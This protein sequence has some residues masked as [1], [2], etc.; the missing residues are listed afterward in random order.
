[1]TNEQ[2]ERWNK[3]FTDA[4]KETNPTKLTALM[5]EIVKTLRERQEALTEKKDPLSLFHFFRLTPDVPGVSGS[6]TA[7][8]YRAARC[9]PSGHGRNNLGGRRTCIRQTAWISCW[10]TVIRS[11]NREM[12]G[13]ER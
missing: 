9:T 7:A 4:A 8:P 1:M 3:L 12:K 5:A 11:Y 6:C 2:M 10:K 13:Q